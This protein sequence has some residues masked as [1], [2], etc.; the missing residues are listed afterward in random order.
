ML[1]SVDRSTSITA[2]PQDLRRTLRWIDYIV[3]R[4][5]ESEALALRLFADER[6]NQ[7]QREGW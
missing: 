5:P 4:L 7:A 2:S 1:S 3:N 6:V